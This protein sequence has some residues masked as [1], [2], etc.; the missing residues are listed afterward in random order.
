MPLL[1]RL[2]LTMGDPVGVGPEVAVRAAIDPQVLAVA[3]PVIVGDATI[4]HRAAE[5]CALRVSIRE[6]PSIDE[7][8]RLA[9]RSTIAVVAPTNAGDGHDATLIDLPVGRVSAR[10]GDASVRYVVHAVEEALAGRVEGIVTAPINKEAINAAGHRF[11]GH[12]ELIAARTGTREAAMMLTTGALRVIHVTTHVAFTRVPALLTPTRLDEVIALFDATLRDLG[13]P[14]P[15]IAVAGLNPHAGEHGL[16]GSD[17]AE[18]IVPAIEAVVER[19]AAGGRLCYVGAGTP[20][21]LA[22]VDDGGRLL[23][24]LCRKTRSAGH[25]SDRD[26]AERLAALVERVVPA[27]PRGKRRIHPATRVFQALRIAVNGEL[28]ALESALASSLDLLTG[29][30]DNRLGR[31]T[32]LLLQ[33]LQWCRGSKRMHSN[34]SSVGTG[35]PVPAERAGHFD[36]NACCDG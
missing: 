7:A 34:R 1:P 33:M 21:R 14:D 31:E 15:R 29:G 6:A 9:D 12:T 19:L 20:G 26:V 11:A 32:E 2:A 28:E 35:V 8:D 30:A 25:C 27:A 22:V 36:R 24:L 13:C 17:E 4:L 18:R 3:R 5:V 10:A 16:F 23:G